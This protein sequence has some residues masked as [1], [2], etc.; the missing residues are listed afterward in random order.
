MG[1]QKVYN[2]PK[3][4]MFY[5]KGSVNSQ[6]PFVD[7]RQRVAPGLFTEVD[8]QWRAKWL[9][10]QELS[11]REKAFHFYYLWDNADF[12]KA[13][14][15]P[16]RRMWQA[17]GDAFE[18]LLRPSMGLQKAFMTKWFIGKTMWLGAFVLTANY[19][20]KYN[21][22]DWSSKGGWKVHTSKPVTMPGNPHYPKKDPQWERVTPS[23]YNDQGFSKMTL[24]LKTSTPLTYN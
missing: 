9:K 23:K 17:P 6:G 15:N 11:K 16:I 24:P 18:R 21:S 1:D 5:G 20:S 2:P 7:V 22:S 4:D 13:R 14:L 8:R 19:Y 3:S 12:R 10:A